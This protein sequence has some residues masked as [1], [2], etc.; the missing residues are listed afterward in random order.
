MSAS[1][2]AKTFKT[3]GRVISK[4]SPEILTGIG[5]AGMVSTTVLAVKAT[6][7]AV[8]ILDEYKETVL[9]DHEKV[10]PVDA[11]KLT[12]KC[13]IPAAI[14]GTVSIGCLIGGSSVSLK[15]NAA[16][17]T[18]CSLSETA[19]REYKDAVVDSGGEKKAK[20]IKEKAVT[21]KLVDNPA[22][23]SEVIY[24]G[25][26]ETLCYDA[27]CGR[28]FKSDRNYIEKVVNVLNRR[29][30]TEMFISLNDFYSELN[31]EPVQV[32][33][34]LGWNINKDQISE[35]EIDYGAHLVDEDTPYMTIDFVKRPQYNYD[36]F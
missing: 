12:W 28:H 15:R 7:K 1:G 24:T 31:L 29:L 21:K 35:I 9:R 34:Y 25:H 36:Q 26:G 10:K 18:A 17:A 3:I 8:K 30:R 23:S 20:T 19:L 2:I 27:L 5:I 16:L 33:Y 14:T 13:Y 4:H 22:K 32:G 11:V 6:P